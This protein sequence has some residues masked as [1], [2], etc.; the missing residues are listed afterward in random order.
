[1]DNANLSAALVAAQ[2]A[3]DVVIKDAKNPHHNYDYAS[4]EEV[5]AVASVALAG[6]ELAF[7]EEGSSFSF[8]PV[9]L[10]KRADRSEK[11]YADGIGGAHG[12]LTVTYALV[13]VSGERQAI[14]HSFPVVP[15]KGRPLDKA[16]AASRTECLAYAL[17]GL[18]LMER[19]PKGHQKR[20]PPKRTALDVSGRNDADR[21]PSPPATMPQPQAQSIA[22]PQRHGPSTN[23]QFAPPAPGHLPRALLAIQ[24]AEKGED[25]L[26]ALSAARQDRTVDPVAAEET[27]AHWL[28][29][30]ATSAKT[31][32]TLTRIE[33]ALRR[34]SLGGKLNRE[35]GDTITKAK[36]AL[37]GASNG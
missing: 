26:V 17:R 15:E 16:L 13:H 34:A 14:T 21:F 12:I 10:L 23:V 27:F 5:V 1:M 33:G 37:A 9:E 28:V 36:R 11:P 30:K 4:A 8:F 32:E 35:I 29:S 7:T 31:E 22:D 19:R 3:V 18:L 6:A 24:E 2:R 25:A 20:A